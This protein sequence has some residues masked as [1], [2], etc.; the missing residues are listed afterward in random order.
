MKA[1][2]ELFIEACKFYFVFFVYIL[3][4]IGILYLI[5]DWWEQEKTRV[6]KN[7]QR[8]NQ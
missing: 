5:M 2:I 6:P 8:K 1:A 4:A 7:K 3:V